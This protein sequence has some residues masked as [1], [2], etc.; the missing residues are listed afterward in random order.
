MIKRVFKFALKLI[1][2]F[3]F[4]SLFLVV[5]YRWVPIYY[6]PLMAIRSVD[7][8]I[9]GARQHQWVSLEE[10]S[11]NL[12]LAVIASEDQRFLN[13]RGFDLDAIR[14]AI[15]EKQ[16]GK[17]LRGGSTISQQTAKNVF[18]WP[19]RSWIRK[20]LESWF[21]LLIETFWSKERILEVYLN[22]IEM[23]PQVYGAEAASRYWFDRSAKELNQD[24]SAA[25]AAILPNPLQYKARPKT[26]YIA[27]RVRWIKRQMINLGPINWEP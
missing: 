27:G 6:T 14:K 9:S 26:N 11:P 19:G 20:G 21:T 24:Q 2:W 7:K 4:I 25:L 8:D 3:V 10:I 16:S 5:V 1:G 22:S 13:H 12:Q 15:E 23:G 17:R 18:L